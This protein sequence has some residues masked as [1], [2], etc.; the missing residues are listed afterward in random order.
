MVDYYVYNA[1]TI[2][3]HARANRHIKGFGKTAF[4]KD[5][6]FNITK[7]AGFIAIETCL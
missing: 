4:Y 3:R 6:S 5:D 1:Y 2:S 7:K